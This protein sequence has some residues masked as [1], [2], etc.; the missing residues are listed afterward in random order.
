MRGVA[1]G[2]NSRAGLQKCTKESTL[3]GDRLICDLGLPRVETCRIAYKDE[4]A[5]EWLLPT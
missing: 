2:F 3:V 1:A 4:R 5:Y